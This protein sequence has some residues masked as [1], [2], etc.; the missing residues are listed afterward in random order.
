M[1][2]YL[3]GTPS[4]KAAL[5]LVER[6]TELLGTKVATLDLQIASADYENQVNEV[7]EAD[8]EMRGFVRELEENHDEGEDDDDV[9]FDD[10]S[11]PDGS[12]EGAVPGALTDEHGNVPS[13]DALAAELEQFLRDQTS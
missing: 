2:H 8:D 12:P 7:V 10:S 6:V 1:P 3:P 4:P 13:G 5:A 11:G 9:E